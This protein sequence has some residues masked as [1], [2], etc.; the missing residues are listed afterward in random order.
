M[1]LEIKLL[2]HEYHLHIW[3][4]ISAWKEYPPKPTVICAGG[5]LIFWGCGTAL[6]NIDSIINS[7]IKIW[8][9]LPER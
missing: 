2:V 4:K 7:A 3:R 8:L 9:P 6:V 1:W 5:S